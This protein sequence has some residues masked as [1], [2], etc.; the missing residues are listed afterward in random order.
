MR[1]RA[2]EDCEYL[3][4]RKKGAEFDY[5]GKGPAPKWLQKIDA[6]GNPI[7]PEPEKKSE[8]EPEKKSEPEP[9]KR[10]P[11]RPVGT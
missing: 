9:E 1:V 11:G 2:L 4:P 10:R 7:V 6:D 3:G 8:P 5:K